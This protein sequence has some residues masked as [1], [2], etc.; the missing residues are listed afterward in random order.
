QVIEINVGS[1]VVLNDDFFLLGLPDDGIVSVARH[2]V[3]VILL[4]REREVRRQQ[5]EEQQQN[6]WVPGRHFYLH[7]EITG[8][9][10]PNIRDQFRNDSFIIK[11][12]NM[13]F[14]ML[15]LKSEL[16]EEC[17]DEQD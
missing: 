16:R 8:R 11:N 9:L 4:L 3:P 12:S 2:R 14:R 1:R 13:K 6:E 17:G 10:R 5:N 7:D 15:T